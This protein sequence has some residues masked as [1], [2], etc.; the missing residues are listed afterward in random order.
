MRKVYIGDFKI[1]E[2]GRKE[3]LEILDSGRISEGVKTR[4]FEKEFANFIGTKFSIALNSGTSALIAGL[5]SLKHLDD[6][7]KPKTK[8]ITSPLNYIA[9]CN[10]IVV[11]GFEPVFVDVDKHTFVITPENI[12]ACLEENDNYSIILPIHQMGYSCDMDEIN[13]IAKEY[14]LRVLED[15]AQA[16]GTTYKGKRTGSLSDLSAFSFYIAH[17]IQAGEMGAITTDNSEINRLVNKIKTHGRMCDCFIC[18]RMNGKCPKLDDHKGE[19]D[20]DPRFTHDIIGY[21]FKITEIQAALGLS[22]LRR[23]DEIIRKRQENVKYL[24]EGLEKFSGV[25]QLPIFSKDVSYLAYPIV[26]KK[27]N[28]ISRKKLRRDLESLGVETRPLFGCIPTRQPAYS[29]LK[30]KYLGK[31]PNAEYS[32]LNGFYIGCHQY[33]TKEDLDY[34]IKQFQEIL[35]PITN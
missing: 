19:D 32:G 4:A 31:L 30:S 3:I 1:L 2:D 26:I 20:F 7:V 9:T 5:E 33:L 34:V 17:N 12:K 21:N 10:S 15:S 14:G 22:Q 35:G 18:T 23:V 13:R 24:N 6:N 16:S 11:S 25:L 28:L 8:V 29:H 27:P